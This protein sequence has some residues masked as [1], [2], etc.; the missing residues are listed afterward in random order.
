MNAPD[1]TDGFY[2]LLPLDKHEYYFKNMTVPARLIASF[3]LLAPGAHAAR[4]KVPVLFAICG[5]DTVAPPK[6]TLA[7][8]KKAPKGVIRY[9][10]D[11]G[12][13]DIYLGEKHDRAW[14]EYR[15][16]ILEALPV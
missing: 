9:F 4:I 16:F 14:K 13:F 2:P 3:P 7:Y 15:E 8:A 10:D 12:H 6:T 1:V 5:K 11:M